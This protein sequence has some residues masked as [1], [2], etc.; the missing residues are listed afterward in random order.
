M[1]DNARLES[2]LALWTEVAGAIKGLFFNKEHETAKGPL[3]EKYQAKL[4]QLNAFVGEKEWVMGYLSLA[5]FVVAEDSNFVQRVYPE[6]YKTW[7]FLQRIRERFNN[8]PEIIAYY[9]KDNAMK[10]PFYPAYA[11]IQIEQ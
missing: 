8:L 5:D 2:F 7:P 9:K 10:G 11:Y 1:K 4:D 6:Q 3:L